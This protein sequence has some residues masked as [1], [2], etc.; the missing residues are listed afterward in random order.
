[1]RKILLALVLPLIAHAL[2]AAAE[3]SILHLGVVGVQD[4]PDVIQFKRMDEKLRAENAGADLVTIRNQP[5]EVAMR[6][7][8]INLEERLRGSDQSFD[9]VVVQA[10]EKD[11]A[12]FWDRFAEGDLVFKGLIGHLKPHARLVF[13]GGPALHLKDS[14]GSFISFESKDRVKSLMHALNIPQG[15][16]L[17]ALTPVHVSRTPAQ[18]VRR[19]A[20]LGATT[21]ALAA[22]MTAVT[23]L[24]NEQDLVESLVPLGALAW[25]VGALSVKETIHRLKHGPPTKGER[26]EMALIDREFNFAQ[27]GLGT[28]ISALAAGLYAGGAQMFDQSFALWTAGV[29][30]AIT[31]TLFYLLYPRKNLVGSYGQPVKYNGAGLFELTTDEPRATFLTTDHPQAFTCPAILTP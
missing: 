15:S 11:Y 30:T 9:L 27:V 14:D 26:E 2:H 1:M 22:G 8:A 31:G 16:V 28:G 10:S 6:E 3:P 12:Y 25:T 5:G 7:L 18:A 4:Q 29:G 13:T 20:L 17:T 23:Y 19:I 21:V 24:P